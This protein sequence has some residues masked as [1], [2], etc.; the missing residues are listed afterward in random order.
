[1]QGGH[2]ERKQMTQHLFTNINKILRSNKASY[3]HCKETISTKKHLQGNVAWSTS[4]VI[5]GW[6]LYTSQEV[7]TL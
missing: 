7:F 1:M 5:L 2:T 6:V 4:E 3:S